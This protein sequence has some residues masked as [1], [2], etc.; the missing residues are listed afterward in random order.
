MENYEGSRTWSSSKRE[1]V[2]IVA[3]RDDVLDAIGLPFMCL[4]GLFP[5]TYKSKNINRRIN[6]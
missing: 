1:R 4:S 2:F 3:V 5:R 6:R